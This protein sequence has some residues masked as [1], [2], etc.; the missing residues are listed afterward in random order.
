[1]VSLLK[2]AFPLAALALL[3]TLFLLARAM[4]TDTAIPF[5]DIEVQERLRDQQITGPFFSGTTQTGDQM[6]FS[7]TKLITLDGTVGTNRAEDVLARLQTAQGATFRLLADTAELDIA[8]N[9]AVL[10][11]DVSMTSSTGYRIDTA[12]ITSL[13]STLDVTA[14]HQVDANGPLGKFTAGNMRIFTPSEGDNTQMLFSG[15][16]KLVYTPNKSGK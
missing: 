14:P 5:A 1:M 15:G 9:S 13:I 2:V 11:G 4:E 7:A 8:E 6:S 12:Q 10:N 16:V 3:S